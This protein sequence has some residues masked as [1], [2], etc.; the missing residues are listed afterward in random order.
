MLQI[1]QQLTAKPQIIF[2]VDTYPNYILNQ[3]SEI[4]FSLGDK[5]FFELV[6]KPHFIRWLRSLRSQFL[7]STNFL[8]LP[9]AYGRPTFI[10]LRCSHSF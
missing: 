3:L 10:L 4:F 5:N 7:A 1:F 6:P 8:S 2:Y 9:I